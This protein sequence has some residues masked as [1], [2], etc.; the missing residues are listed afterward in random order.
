MKRNLLCAAL[1]LSAFTAFGGAMPAGTHE[2]RLDVASD[3]QGNPGIQSLPI[4]GGVG[5][6]FLDN[7][8]GGLYVSWRDTQWTATG[9]RMRLSASASSENMISVP[10]P[11][12]GHLSPPEPARSAVTNKATRRGSSPGEADSGSL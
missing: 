2:F 4:I 9:A 3:F 1:V 8:E 12:C 10:M 6:F 5:Y 7:M 11:C